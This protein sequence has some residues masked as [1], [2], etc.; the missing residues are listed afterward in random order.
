MKRKSRGRVDSRLASSLKWTVSWS[1]IGSIEARSRKDRKVAHVVNPVL[2]RKELLDAGVS[3]SETSSRF[4]LF[5]R[6]RRGRCRGVLFRTTTPHLSRP[7][8]E[9]YHREAVREPVIV[10]LISRL[11][12]R[13]RNSFR[14]QVLSIGFIVAET[15]TAGHV[16]PVANRV[17]CTLPRIQPACYTRILENQLLTPS[18]LFPPLLE[19]PFHPTRFLQLFVTQRRR[20]RH[21]RV[22]MDGTMKNRSFF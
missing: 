12:P 7:T 6:F 2:S 15:V 4:H 22:I 14:G 11:T 10:P 19:N 1:I 17:R 13:N 3:R 18:L 5:R 16:S 9:E 20:T 8:C 21:A